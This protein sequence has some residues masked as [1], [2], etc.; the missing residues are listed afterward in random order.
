MRIIQEIVY[1]FI[2]TPFVLGQ[3]LSLYVLSVKSLSH[4]QT[5]CEPH[6]LQPARLLCPWNS[7]G[8]IT[9]V[10]CPFLLQGIFSTQGSNSG[11]PHCRQIF[12]CL[13]FLYIFQINVGSWLWD[14]SIFIPILCRFSLVQ[15][16]PT[17][18]DP[19]DSSI[20]GFPVHQLPEFA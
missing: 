9:G 4:V 11:L 14:R 10:G 7:P 13:N 18:F 3:M 15:S 12:Y 8:N 19:M 2:S 17:L 16:C 6:G 1:Y 5:L 20:L